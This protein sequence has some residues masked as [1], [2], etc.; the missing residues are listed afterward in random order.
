MPKAVN[1]IKHPSFW[2]GLVRLFLLSLIFVSCENDDTDFSAYINGEVTNDCTIYIA[3]NGNTVTVTGD[4][5]GFVTVNG[6]HVTVNTANHS[7]SLLLVL[8]GSSDNGSLLVWREKKYG[9]Q[10]NGLTLN[11]ANGPAI[12]NQCKKALYLYANPGT[13][14]TLTDGTAYTDA[15]NAAGEAISQKG[16]LF[17]EGQ[18]YLMGNGTL[19]VTGN[20]RHAIA[21]DDYIIVDGNITLNV[22][23]S[24]GTGIKVNDGLWINSGKID[25]NV[26]ADAA[27][28]IKSDSVVVIT[29]GSTTITTSG[30]CVYDKEEDDYS[31]AACIKCD[32]DFTMSNGT[33]TMTSSGD[34]GK[35]INTSGKVEFSGGTLTATTT[36]DNEDGKPKAIKAMTGIL[37]SGGSFAAKV[38][39]SW[40]CDSGY[41]DDSTSDSDR[42]DHCVTITGNPTVATIAK[43]NVVITY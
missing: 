36:G 23:S 32:R 8:S 7:D 4:D 39:K 37:V 20:C 24:T 21:S 13:A 1:T 34:G 38:S 29:G 10:L 14:N 25:I 30:D 9:I 11:N 16:A 33:L 35:C 2:E 43:K 28:G 5:K 31:S 18:I 3:Y 17:S 41:G 42:L 19:N 12:N 27:R 22:K 26:T 15:T 6:A 40:A